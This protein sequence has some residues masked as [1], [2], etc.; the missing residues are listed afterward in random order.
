[1]QDS[2]YYC[3]DNRITMVSKYQHS[4]NASFNDDEE[5]LQHCPPLP[6]K[7]IVT[8]EKA[9]IL[10]EDFKPRAKPNY[11][12]KGDLIEAISQNE[13]WIKVS[14]KN[15]AKFGWI[16]KNNLRPIED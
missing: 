14:Y 10:D 16:D 2:A 7:Y 3:I 8:T 13:D 12:I 5:L 4:T 15:G 9:D 6:N 11:Y 1:M